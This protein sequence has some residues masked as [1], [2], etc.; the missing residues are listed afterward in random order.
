VASLKTLRSRRA[1][2][3]KGRKRQR[4]LFRKTGERGHARKAA[5]YGQAMRK[6][7]K[8]ILRKIRQ[9]RI[10]WNGCEPLPLS[11]RKARKAAAWVLHHV[12]GLYISSTV[13][14]DSVTYHGPSQRRAIDFGSDDPREGPERKAQH[15]LYEHFGAAYFLELF[16]PDNDHW[17]KNGSPYT[18]SEGEYLETLHDDHTHMAA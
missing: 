13:R 7:T 12:D 9:G 11:R 5:Q 18:A 17:V 1:N 6:L 16:G 3:G 8:L 15:K 2:R 10:D 4:R 14:Y